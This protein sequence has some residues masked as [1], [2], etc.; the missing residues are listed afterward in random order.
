MR[1]GELTVGEVLTKL[2]A[3]ERSPEKLE[4]G[5]SDTVSEIVNISGK[6]Q[7]S[8]QRIVSLQILPPEVREAVRA[9]KLTMSQGYTFADNISHPGFAEILAEAPKMSYFNRYSMPLFPRYCGMEWRKPG[10]L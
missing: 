3:Y 8:V 6:S 10:I 7:R 1:H 4:K 9:G 5:L 2:I